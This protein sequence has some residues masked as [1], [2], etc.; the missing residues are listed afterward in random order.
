M[1]KKLYYLKNITFVIV[2]FLF[3]LAFPHL[4]MVIDG[5]INKTMVCLLL[6]IILFIQLIVLWRRNG[7]VNSNNWYH[8][9]FLITNLI[10]IM[11]YLRTCFDT[12]IV[13]VYRHME[14]EQYLFLYYNLGW[15]VILYSI[16]IIYPMTY[17]TFE[18]RSYPKK[19]E[20]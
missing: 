7:K 2:C 4:N 19:N 6:F 16:L 8:G 20:K 5:G 10:F 3:A 18:K 11:L 14:D 12:S 9:L 15:I 13:T 1:N 17:A